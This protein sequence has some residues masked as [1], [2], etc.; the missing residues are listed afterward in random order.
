MIKLELKVTES[1]KKTEAEDSKTFT[2]VELIET[3]LNNPP[4][5]AEGKAAG[6]TFTELRAR[7]RISEV[8]KDKSGETVE[9]E[10]NDMDKLRALT[11][12]YQWPMRHPD[13][14]TFCT[15]IMGE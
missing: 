9:F 11:K 15:A 12:N 3:V 4:K 8:I 10:D 6:F 2:Y 13:I 7:Q 1:M 14:L 5:D